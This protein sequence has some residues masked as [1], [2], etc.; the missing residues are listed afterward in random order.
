M[1][2]TTETADAGQTDPDTGADTPDHAAEA[3]KWKALARKHEAQAKAN[4]KAAKEL[5]EFRKQSMTETEQAVEEARNDGRRQALVEAGSRIAAAEVRAAATGRLTADQ[6]D[7]LLDGINLARFVS[8]EGEVD[9]TAV[10]KFVDGIAPQP[11]G[12]TAAFDLGQGARDPNG[13]PKDPERQ[14]A[15]QLFNSQ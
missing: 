1:S 12:R 5:D 7:T 8:D 2:D 11:E 6:L 14:F 9:Q 3:E 13:A 10:A 15:R 4:A